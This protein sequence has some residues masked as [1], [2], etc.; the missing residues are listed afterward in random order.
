MF[1]FACIKNRKMAD[2][3]ATLEILYQVAMIFHPHPQSWSKNYLARV[4][5]YMMMIVFMA[6]ATIFDVVMT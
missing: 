2:W 3:L 4:Q 1:T 6:S 5:R